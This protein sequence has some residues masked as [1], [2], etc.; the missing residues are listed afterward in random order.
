MSAG[1]GDPCLVCLVPLRQNNSMGI[2]KRNPVCSNAY[3][4]AY[5]ETHKEQKAATDAA[6]GAANK[7]RIAV[8]R[9]DY[10]ETNRVD[11][12]TEARARYE[13]NKEGE[14]ARSAAYQR[15]NPEKM[16]AYVARRKVRVSTNMDQLD[17][18][19]SVAYRKAIANDSCFYCGGPGEQDDHYTSLANGGTDH[20][21]NL[22]R[23]CAPC[24]LHKNR[25]NGDEFVSLLTTIGVGL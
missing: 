7:E 6:Y 20:W 12:N 21:W 18:E 16:R 8:R 22:V 10:R 11:L 2:C 24:N 13:V 19:L 1:R 15:A 17:R 9:A 23:A 5:H 14:R 3:D 4:A 25:M